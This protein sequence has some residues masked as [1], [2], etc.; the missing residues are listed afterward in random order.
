MPEKYTPPP[1]RSHHR[2]LPDTE[3]R[4]GQPTPPGW[5]MVAKGVWVHENGARVEYTGRTA[6]YRYLASDPDNIRA[7][8]PSRA[9]AFAWAQGDVL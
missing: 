2:R 4:R 6:D 3:P 5:T 8:F 7:Y 1:W 9:E